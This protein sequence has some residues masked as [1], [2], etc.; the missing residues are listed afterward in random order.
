MTKKEKKVKRPK[1][2]PQIEGGEDSDGKLEKKEESTKEENNKERTLTSDSTDKAETNTRVGEFQVGFIFN[3]Q[4]SSSLRSEI[5]NAFVNKS[6]NTFTTD[7]KAEIENPLKEEEI[8]L[9]LDETTKEKNQRSEQDELFLRLYKETSIQ[10]KIHDTVDPE[11][12]LFTHVNNSSLDK[13]SY[14]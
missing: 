3:L 8:H 6:N 4:K 7:L 11:Q 2:E 13:I 5:S 1:K 10:I 12:Y 9:Y 14:L